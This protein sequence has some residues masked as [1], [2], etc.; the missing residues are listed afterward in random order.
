MLENTLHC[1]INSFFRTILR[2]KPLFASSPSGRLSD[3]QT[4]ALKTPPPFE[5]AYTHGFPV[6][7]SVAQDARVEQDSAS[8]TEHQLGG[9]MHKILLACNTSPL[10]QLESDKFIAPIH[11]MLKGFGNFDPPAKKKLA[12]HLDLLIF[13]CKNTYTGRK[14]P[15]WQA[16][17]T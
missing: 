6:A 17:A 14:S 11:H 12:C 2:K 15:L 5:L 10:K 1:E 13:A 8:Y 3:S 16:R 7:S 9:V 4:A